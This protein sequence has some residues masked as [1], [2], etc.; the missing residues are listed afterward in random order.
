MNNDLADHIAALILES[1]AGAGRSN[2]AFIEDIKERIREKFNLEVSEI[3]LNSA[4][5]R[6]QILDAIQR[7]PSSFAGDLIEISRANALRYFGDDAMFPGPGTSLE[8]DAVFEEANSSFLPIKAYSY[9]G[10]SWVDRVVAGLSM[11]QLDE[12][13]VV[14]ADFQSVIIPA[15]DRVV[16]INDNSRQEIDNAAEDLYGRLKSENSINGDVDLRDRFIAQIAAGRELLRAGSV[17]VYLIQETLLRMLSSII[18]NYK[19][20][21]IAEAAKKLFDLLLDHIFKS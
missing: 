5:D 3:L 4:L 2:G 16:T 20:Q 9:G 8:Y 1:F 7:L 15:S 12:I 10:K 19:D 21:A 13:E 18:H 17:R 11:A 6:L 14:S